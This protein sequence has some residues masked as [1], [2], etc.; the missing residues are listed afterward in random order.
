MVRV[1][2][3]PLAAV[4]L[5]TPSDR[6]SRVVGSADAASDLETS[7]VDGEPQFG[8]MCLP[9]ASTTPRN[10]VGTW[11]R[12]EG[13]A[14]EVPDPYRD[15]CGEDDEAGEAYAEEH[16]AL[17]GGAGLRQVVGVVR[18]ARIVRDRRGRPD[19]WFVAAVGRLEPNR[20][21]PRTLA[22]EAGVRVERE[23]G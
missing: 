19:V 1:A 20:R 15:R 6:R 9:H 11:V 14:G 23:F 21:Q 7:G 17:P 13:F 5:L 3:T 10:V 22:L 12:L 16:R 8:A 2:Q 18:I 4:G